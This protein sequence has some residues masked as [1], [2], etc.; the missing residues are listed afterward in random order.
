MRVLIVFLLFLV[1]AF[2][3]EFTT[4]IGDGSRYQ[5]AAMTTD[6]AGNTYLAGARYLNIPSLAGDPLPDV[7]VAKVYPTGKLIFD[8]TFGGK[9]ADTPTAIAIDPQGNVYVAGSTTSPDYPR[10]H[11]IV[12][13]PSA[14]PAGFLTKLSPD[15][16]A[17]LYST[18]FNASIAAL[19][20]DPAGNLYVAGSAPACSFPNTAKLPPLPFSCANY[21]NSLVTAAFVA[22]IPPDGGSILYSGL[23]AGAGVPCKPAPGTGCVI[24]G[25]T[26]AVSLAVD[27]SGNAYLAGN[28]NSTDLPVTP[29]AVTPSGVGAFA[30]KIHSGGSALDYLTYIEPLHQLSSGVTAPTTTANAIAIDASGNAYLAGATHTFN[31]PATAG[32]FQ[33]AFGGPATNPPYFGTPPDAFLLKLNPTATAFDWATY[34]GG[35]G[36]DQATALAVD[37]SG[38]VWA[39]GTTTS[40][41]FPNSD[42]WSSGGDFLVEL[43]STGSALRYSGRYPGGTI[44]QGIGL[45]STPGL[46]HAA[47]ANGLVSLLAPTQTPTM[48]VFGI[49]S[50]AGGPIDGLVSSEEAASLYGPN[51]GPSG[52]VRATPDSSGNLPTSLAGVTVSVGGTDAPLLYVSAS[53]IDFVIPYVSGAQAPIRIQNGSVS[54]PDFNAVFVQATPVVFSNPDG[55]AAAINQDGTVNSRSNPAPRGSIVSIWATG[56][57]ASSP[58]GTIA[59]AA[60]DSCGVYCAVGLYQQGNVTLGPITSYANVVYAGAAPGLPA[61]ITQINFEIPETALDSIEFSAGIYPQFSPPVILWVR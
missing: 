56:L 3:Q 38:N 50:L 47:G 51:I 12:Y 33:T 20:T 25:A 8:V 53:R 44:S 35:A 37:P 34:L 28:T 14:T 49:Q 57:G 4:Y 27:P 10:S 42:G 31:F 16:A 17:I 11:A 9:G 61:G 7:F 15:G 19:A 54:S 39:T 26:S 40:A 22:E 43:N 48:R 24:S 30:A 58:I 45:E 32:A 59:S 1:S 36:S 41:N 6:A 2:A 5:T 55:T 52:P 60:N 46:V 29:G 13:F 18:Y 21:D 23:I